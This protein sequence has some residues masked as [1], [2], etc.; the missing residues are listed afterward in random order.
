MTQPQTLSSFHITMLREIF[1]VKNLA[2]KFDATSLLGG[3]YNIISDCAQT[4]NVFDMEHL[5]RDWHEDA[6]FRFQVIF[7]KLSALPLHLIL[8]FL[9]CNGH[10][11]PIFSFLMV[12]PTKS[13]TPHPPSWKPFQARRNTS[14]ED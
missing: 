3:T 4:R 12:F 10:V 5:K 14:K 9:R 1:D 2:Q 11:N 8:F 6:T 13:S 7:I